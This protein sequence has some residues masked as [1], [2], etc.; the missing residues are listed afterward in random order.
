MAGT[1]DPTTD[2]NV[3]PFIAAF[4]STV[5]K[6]DGSVVKGIFFEDY[7]SDDPSDRF[8]GTTGTVLRLPN[9]DLEGLSNQDPISVGSTEF[10]ISNIFPG[11]TGWALVVLNR[12]RSR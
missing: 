6:P 12:R 10:T 3:L 7:R 2:Q 5:T 1:F 9:S 11:D 4:G 8:V